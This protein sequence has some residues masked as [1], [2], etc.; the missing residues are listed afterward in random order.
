MN[1][2]LSGDKVD[3]QVLIDA[4]DVTNK[5]DL[6]QDPITI[7]SAINDELDTLDLTVHEGDG[8]AIL[9]WK[10]VLIKDGSNA[11]FGGYHLTK[12]Q[13]EAVNRTKNNYQIGASD[14]GAYLDKVFYQGEFDNLS[15]EAIIAAVFAA[16]P[17]LA[18]FDATSFVSTVRTISRVVFNLVSVKDVINWLADQSGANWYLDYDKK[19][20]YFGNVEYPSPF[21]ITADPTDTANAV[22]K[23]VVVSGN[24]S[25]VVNVIELLGGMSLSNNSTYEFTQGLISVDLYM[26]QKFKPWDTASKIVVR[27]N[28]GGPTTNL[29]VNP[30]F[31]TN[32]TDGWTQVQAGSGAVWTQDATKYASGAKSLKIT[33]GTARAKVYS[34]NI[35][36]APGESLS[37][38]AMAYTATLGMASLLICDTSSLATLAEQSNRKTSSWEKLTANYT[39]LTA[40]TLTVRLELKNYATDSALATYFDAVQAEKL[41]WASAYCDGSLGTGY[42][43]TGTANN[44]TSTRVNMPVWTTL[45]VKIGNSDTLSAR[46]EVLYFESL[47]KLTQE[48]NWPTM[49]DA[50]EV[51]GRIETPVHVVVRNY[52]SY[53]HYG[54]WFKSVINDSSIVDPIVA[55]IRCATELAEN[56][57]ETTA[58]SYDVH[59]PGLRA[60][61]TQTINLPARGINASYLIKRVTTT[62]SLG[63][64]VVSRVE[65]GAVDATLVGLLLKLKAASSITTSSISSDQKLNRVLDFADKI[66]FTDLGITVTG[67]TG[68]Y[69]WGTANWG[70]SVWG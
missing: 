11:I 10:E 15:D 35:S 49:A 13:K 9:G 41:A 8:L 38:Q 54:K 20:H 63:G 46:N 66:S 31:E 22:V 17:E 59:R 58:I 67:S 43:W 30:S 28:D 3:L 51:D 34:A 1:E 24:A 23:N 36:L 16:S 37:A 45:T 65:L 18:S 53:A 57:F 6:N 42:A 2:L 68:P 48:T 33:A 27:R 55:R 44:S 32:I 64:H 29:I 70:F 60:G 21:N 14:F 19:L 7:T 56:A 61:Q 50:I 5:I 47:G 40:A 62:I 4:V 26:N 39:N 25:S 52:A 69:L 12:D